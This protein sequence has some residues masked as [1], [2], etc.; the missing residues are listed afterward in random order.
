M[1]EENLSYYKSLVSMGYDD[2]IILLLDKYGVATEDYFKEES[3]KRFM[4]GEMKSITKAKTSRTGEGLYCHHIDEDKY[5][6]LAEKN[7]IKANKCSFELQKKERLVYC[8]LIEHLILHSLIASKTDGKYGYPGYQVFIKPTVVDWYI[9]GKIPKP[10]WMKNCYNKAYLTKNE[11]KQLLGLIEETLLKKIK[12]QEKEKYE[13]LLRIRDKEREEEDEKLRINEIENQIRI[14]QEK[15]EFEKQNPY[16]AEL[17]IYPTST[18]QK[19]IN[20]MYKLKYNEQYD[21]KKAFQSSMLEKY[22]DE[23]FEEL[24]EI[25]IKR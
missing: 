7:F 12:D 23:L 22:T 13:E 19:L 14:D 9:E 5:L 6:N 25:V 20:T 11:T 17:G 24:K 8:D 4:N 1:C 10:D 3:Y 15:K 18:R 2:V 21:T 16:L